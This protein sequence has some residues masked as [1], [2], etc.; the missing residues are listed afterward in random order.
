M[1]RLHK[2]K[3]ERLPLGERIDFNI[4]QFRALQVPRGWDKLYVT[5]ISV[6]TGKTIARLSKSAV[7][8]NGSC[9]WSESLT[10]SVWVSSDELSKELEDC[11]FKFVVAM[12]S[13]RSGI[14]GEATVNMASY[15]RSGSSVLASFPLKKCDYGTVLQAKIQC[16]TPVAILSCRFYR[17]CRK[18][19]S[20]LTNEHISRDGGGKGENL[21]KEDAKRD[22]GDGGKEFDQEFDSP[23]DKSPASYSTSD[24]ASTPHQADPETREV[25]SS[26]TNSPRSDDSGDLAVASLER[27]RDATRRGNVAS[28]VGYF[29]DSPKSDTPLST[30]RIPRSGRL[31][32]SGTDG[33]D[34]SLRIMDSSSQTMLE[35]A[36]ETIEDLRGQGRMWERT[37]RKLMLEMDFLK[38]EHVELSRNQGNLVMEFSEACAERDGLRKEV[39]H[40]KQMLVKAKQKPPPLNDHPK[41]GAW[42]LAKEL[43]REISFQKQANGNL[44][45]QL[46]R[47]QESNLELV[48]VLQDLEETLEKQK[49]EIEGLYDMESRFGELEDALEESLEKNRNLMVQILNLQESEKGMQNK[50]NELELALEK[51]TMKTDDGE[52]TGELGEVRAELKRLKAALDSKEVENADLQRYKSESEARIYDLEKEK[53]QAELDLE[54]VTRENEIASRCL[55]DLQNDLTMI[56]SNVDTHVSVNKRRTL[57][58][59]RNRH[60]LELCLSELRQEN[61]DLSTHIVELETR[62]SCRSESSEH[63][64]QICDL[65]EELK[66]KLLKDKTEIDDTVS[67]QE[68][69]KLKFELEVKVT[70]LS[71]QLDESKMEI[72]RLEA[73]LHS[74]EE[75]I[76]TLQR[77][78]SGLEAK[79]SVIH[80]EKDLLEQKMEAIM[81]ENDMATRCFSELQSE[82]IMIGN[83]VDSHI[84]A[85]ESL[86]RKCLE[87][88]KQKYSLEQQLSRIEQDNDELLMRITDLETQLRSEAASELVS[89]MHILEEKEEQL[90]E[91]ENKC[92]N[93][94]QEFES[95]RNER[96]VTVSEHTKV[97]S[98]RMSGIKV[99]EAVIQSKEEEIGNLKTS[100]RESES[101]FLALEKEKCQLEHDMETV[102][103]ENV[104]ARNRVK[105]LLSSIDSLAPGKIIPERRST[106]LGTD[107][108]D[109]QPHLSVK[110]Q[111]NQRFSSIIDNLEVKTL[112]LKSERE[113]TLLELEK[114]KFEARNLQD[115][116]A[117]LRNEIETEKMNMKNQLLR[118][119]NECLASQEK[120]EHLKNAENQSFRE[121]IAAFKENQERLESENRRISCLLEDYKVS[122]EKFR[123]NINDLEL[124]LTVSEYDRQV[125]K[126]EAMELKT[127][128]LKLRPVHEQV[129]VLKNELSTAKSEKENLKSSLHSLTRE[130]QQMEAEK[131]SLQEEIVVLQKLVAEL[132]EQKR[133]RLVLE[134]KLKQ[135]E[136]DLMAKEALCERDEELSNE[137]NKIRKANKQL[138]NRIQELEDE[139][140]DC[141]ERARTL[142]EELV[143]LQEEQLI[144]SQNQAINNIDFS[145]QTNQKEEENDGR[146]EDKNGKSISNELS[147][148]RSLNSSQSIQTERVESELGQKSNNN[149][150]GENP[151]LESTQD[152]STEEEESPLERELREIRERYLH[153]SLK[154]AE[155]EAQRGELIMR[156]R[157]ATNGKV[158]F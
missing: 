130:Y 35:A 112:H 62:L 83:S 104:E 111:E 41:E 5:V 157:A 14:L 90:R 88:E 70:E 1:F 26:T 50:V 98:E 122:E 123:T 59:E 24:T 76:I 78:K 19:R 52:L 51:G 95:M 38:K 120:N 125:V 18:M 100:S 8:R 126:E 47:S 39:A 154:Y 134:E 11:V 67:E 156:L 139:K 45:L 20:V 75:E 135:T 58:L 118:V 142:E 34:G 43:E 68:I 151:N 91:A 117:R 31:S 7:S 106:E 87:L 66:K 27:T 54:L 140:E 80:E 16:L 146:T 4:S 158:S 150:G 107:N 72:E 64:P 17:H 13:T 29:L 48:A 49:V 97:L 86:E 33:Q 46:N 121:E 94:S 57:E 10:E 141:M 6:E 132:E 153:M 85:K 116:V 3:S 42:E 149:S 36:E 32:N 2:I 53:S 124:K 93:L 44:T 22:S 128:L 25:S 96:E 15:M 115:E 61:E 101:E 73:T 28:R 63:A 92:N 147:N 113:S 127:E 21:L 137:L 155:V 77:W 9:D 89:L 71:T 40:L 60:K 81:T 129:L 12:G 145:N 114:S 30:R 138:Q 102:M 144:H 148:T 131:N 23:F 103:R 55:N 79:L 84:S 119:N 136:N 143:R 69:E 152:E 74:H 133:H 105:D 109:L 65:E 110:Y 82:L 108:Q 99:L 56:S 37:A